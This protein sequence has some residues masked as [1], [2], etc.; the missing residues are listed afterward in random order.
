MLWIFFLIVS[1]LV[2]GA[3]SSDDIVL[4]GGVGSVNKNAPYVIQQYYGLMSLICLLMVTAFMNATANRDF[5]TGMYQFIF[6]SPIKERNYFFGKFFGAYLI[7]IIPLLGVS[8]GSIIG[9]YMPWASEGRYGDVILNGHLYGILGFAIPN[10]FIAGSFIYALAIIFRSNLVSYIGTMGLLV[11]YVSAGNFISD[12]EKEWLANILDP[13]GFRPLGTLTKYQTVDEKNLSAMGLQG[14]FLLNRLVWMSIA[15][16]VLLLSYTRFNFMA[17]KE[18]SNKKA[19]SSS[20]LVQPK[21]VQTPVKIFTPKVSNGFS[22]SS[23]FSAT[24][25][26]T[27]SI[28][29]NQTFLIIVII[30]LIN[31][32]GSLTSFS[33]NYGSS[34]YPVTYSVISSISGSFY[35]FLIGI[36]TFYSGV[37]VWRDRDAKINEIKDATPVSTGL[38]FSSKLI[39]LLIAI[40]VVL[41]STIVV[42][43]IAQ[44][45]YGYYNFEL[46]VYIKLLLVKDFLA[47]AY[48]AV[49]AIFFQ[50]LINNRYIAYFAFVA[51]VIVNGFIWNV[52]KI[53]T[54]MLSFGTVPSIVY[55]SMNQ[56]GPWV[57]SVV[58]FNLYWTLFCVILCFIIYAFYVRGKETKFGTRLRYAGQRLKLN[59]ATF[60]LTIVAFAACASF[61]Y[62][63]TLVLNPFYNSDEMEKIQHD[64]ELT[65]KQYEGIVQPRWISINYYMDLYPESRDLKYKANA[66]ITN[67]SGEPITEL[68]FSMPDLPDTLQINIPGA[69]LTLNDKKHYYRIYTLAEPMQP[70]DTLPVELIGEYITKGFE[71]SVS[72]TSIVKN[73]SF[74]N[75]NSLVPGFGYNR[76]FEVSDKNKRQKLGLPARSRMAK[77]DDNNLAARANSYISNDADWVEIKTIFGT[78]GNQIAVAPG[79]LVKQWQ[80]NGR[81]YFEYHQDYKSVMFTSF[82]SAEFEVARE[83]WNDVDLEVYYTKGH[84]YNVPNMLAS[85]RKS[86]EYYTQNFGPYYHKQCRIIE[87]PRY[88][89]FAQAFPGTMPYSEGIGFITDLRKVTKDDIDVV[90]YVVAHE[91]AHQYWAHQVIGPNMRGS[92]MFSESFAQYSSL[93]V[94]EKE[95]GR[96]KMN[97]FLRYEMN[98]YLT[99]RSYETQAERPLME[100]EG[101][102]YIHYNKGSVIMYY[103]KEMIGEDKVNLAMQNIIQKYAYAE[104][105]YPTSVSIVNELKAQIPDSLQ[106]LVK[107]LFETITL[108]S[109]R[110]DEASYTKIGDNEFEV[111]FNTI[112]E[113]FVA[114]SLGKETALPLK[115]YIDVGV[116]AK[117]NHSNNLGEPLLYKRLKLTQKENTFTFRVNQEPHE[118]GIDPYNYLIDRLPKD[119]VKRVSLKN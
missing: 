78:S 15:F 66:F 74:F 57:Q 46:G 116:F 75:H 87:F 18:K 28:L 62:Y 47:F 4:G 56:F 91:M 22:V 83:K 48:L 49:A 5:S 9:P 40:Q 99:G 50:Y 79:S 26:E 12:I 88:A 77:L 114:D 19:D 32:I 96:N 11:F 103:L 63:N 67:K 101:Q 21:T 34:L 118:V 17:K 97:K 54:N 1:L 39:A 61:V 31:M 59:A 85:M 25:F 8:L 94:M 37:L 10:V 105:P 111:T 14:Q 51:F 113:K 98:S 70:G 42:G 112:S 81:N 117:S 64:Y 119:N 86:L 93:M 69:S 29:K 58:W 73:G 104:P 2:F 55:S 24:L 65:Y 45:F 7:A 6:T 89:S 33:G 110:V 52:L 68:H 90:F 108:F 30:G 72:N 115:D 27:K 109:N 76:G 84:E 106:Y 16:L 53:D 38:L 3:V 80:E 44:S 43:V 36:I 95:Y 13:F 102:G 92:E 107:D 41:A 100:I 60:G 23:F 82:I 20:D 35:L 71:N